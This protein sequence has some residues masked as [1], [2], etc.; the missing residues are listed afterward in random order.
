MGCAL[1][2]AIAAVRTPAITNGGRAARSSE[3]AY[4]RL[5]APTINI[6]GVN[7]AARRVRLRGHAV[8]QAFE[9]LPLKDST[10]A[11]IGMR[12]SISDAASNEFLTTNAPG[13]LMPLAAKGS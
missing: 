13:S 12:I 4:Q 9:R 5:A 8:I 7:H 3:S 10:N 2:S 6:K 1:Q 11:A